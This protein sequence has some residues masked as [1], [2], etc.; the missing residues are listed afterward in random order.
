MFD[1]SPIQIILVL[2]IALVV[3][4]PKRLPELGR[5]LG[6]GIRDFKDGLT[7]ESTHN[8]S[9]AEHL[10]AGI[11]DLKDQVTGESHNGD[12][13]VKDKLAAAHTVARTPED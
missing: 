7:G 12:A 5:N 10:G 8:D 11:R 3:F 4:G 9:P 1:V 13:G 6:S 2:A